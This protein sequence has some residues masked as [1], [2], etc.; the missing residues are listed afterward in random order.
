[1]SFRALASDARFASRALLEQRSLDRSRVVVRRLFSRGL[2]P[3][4]LG[5]PGSL[6]ACSILGGVRESPDALQA[7]TEAVGTAL[8]AD[9]VVV[10]FR[11]ESSGD[12]VARTVWATSSAVSAELV[13]S[14]HRPGAEPDTNGS[15]LRVPIR[16]GDQIVGELELVRLG[17]PFGQDDRPLAQSAAAHAGLVLATELGVGG[18]G[19]GGRR[20]RELRLA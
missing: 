4:R 15:V 17:E 5:H 8:R 14:R 9:A 2:A 7:L 12:L 6:W 18:E 11:E 20:E 10:R 19:G 16:R 1:M 13:G 3:C